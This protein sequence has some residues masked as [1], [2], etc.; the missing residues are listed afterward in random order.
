[1]TFR[2][3]LAALAVLLLSAALQADEAKPVD[4][5][6]KMAYGLM[7][8]QGDRLIFS[9]CR[10]RS[11]ANV[12][13]VSADGSVTRVLNSVG[14][15]AGKRLY[16]ELLGVLDNGTLKASA[17]NMAR[18]EGRCQMP[19]GKE[20]AWRAAGNDPAWALVAGGEHVRLQRY[21]KPEVVLPYTEFRSEGNLSRYDG[22]SDHY[23]LAVRLDKTI[24]RDAQANGAFAWTA[25]VEL[26]GQVLKGCAWQR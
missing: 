16:V 3:S 11:Y 26:N 5:T 25:S 6:P 7:M 8:K 9:P 23:K 17:F 19:G 12:E 4:A 24:C 14:L 20:E 22:A 21:G 13:D 1:M 18:V 10:D 15:D 2:H